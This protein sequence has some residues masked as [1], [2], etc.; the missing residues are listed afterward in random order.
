[1]VGR[2]VSEQAGLV[3]EIARFYIVYIELNGITSLLRRRHDFPTSVELVGSLQV[4][5]SDH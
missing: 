4:L 5:T 2:T 1:M 3:T